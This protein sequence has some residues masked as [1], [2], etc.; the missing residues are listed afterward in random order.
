M[1]YK[2]NCEV[3]KRKLNVDIVLI[4]N[5]RYFFFYVKIG[6]KKQDA[7]RYFFLLLSIDFENIQVSF[8]NQ[9]EEFQI[10]FFCLRQERIQYY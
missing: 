7:N 1:I 10:N 5:K 4:V 9:F 2:N 6:N 8:I 3:V